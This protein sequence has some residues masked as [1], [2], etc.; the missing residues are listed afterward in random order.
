MRY[1]ARK[2]GLTASDEKSL[3]RQDLVEQQLRDIAFS[4]IFGVLLNKAEF[5]QNKKKYL[6]ETLPEHMD[7]L[8]KFLGKNEWLVNKITYVDFIAYEL[9]DWLRIFSPN[10]LDKWQNLQQFIERFESLPAIAAYMKSDEFKDW[11]LVAPVASW[12][13]FK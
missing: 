13:F 12:G 7:L 2:H 8:S 3:M 10:C 5:E 1:L 9:L 6:N 4:F 11:P